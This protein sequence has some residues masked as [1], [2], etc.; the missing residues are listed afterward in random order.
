MAGSS[1]LFPL[2]L[3][4]SS[5]MYFSGPPCILIL[6]PGS[7]VGPHSP[8]HLPSRYS[9]HHQISPTVL[10]VALTHP[11][12]LKLPH[13]MRIH[14][15]FHV[16]QIKPVRS[17]PLCPPSRPPPP[18]RLVDGLPARSI[19]RIMDSRR[20]GRGCQYLVDWA[21][22]G[23]EERSWVLFWI[24][25]WFGSFT[26][27]I[28]TSLLSAGS[29]PWPTDLGMIST[30]AADYE[31]ECYLRWRTCSNRRWIVEPSAFPLDLFPVHCD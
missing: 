5:R 23:V 3:P 2:G 19:T 20:R 31:L 10:L 14:D 13:N 22:Y 11:R 8:V 29:R 16:T 21:G 25:T 28:R 18:A 30:P 1:V 4:A 7:A 12:K 27:C 6:V 17:S 26:A 24:R 9:S 15:V